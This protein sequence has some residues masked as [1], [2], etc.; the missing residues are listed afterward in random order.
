MSGLSR[1][2][3]L[4]IEFDGT[5]FVGWQIQKEQRSVQQ[6][7][8]DTLRQFLQDPE[9]RITGS[10]RTDAGVHALGMGVSFKTTHTIPLRGLVLG[11]NSQ[12]PL[13]IVA[14]DAREVPDDFCARHW[15]RG[16]RY[17]YKVW[18]S[19]LPSALQR[20]RAWHIH[21][22]LDLRA[23]YEGSRAL[24][25]RHDFS[26]FRAAGCSATHPFRDIYE[27]SISRQ[28]S[29]VFLEFEGSAFLRY[30]VRNLA[31][32]LLEVGKG[33]KP[34]EWIAELLASKDRSLGAPTAPAT[35]LY[36]VGVNYNLPP[37]SEQTTT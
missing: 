20:K 30:M 7:L 8:R 9:L 4:T 10:G 29:E 34:P 15:A 25:G 13:D 5:N 35:G 33:T 12:L 27:I 3:L 31:G 11:L 2:I 32:S 37:K 17:R 18:N 26:A 36:L 22:P 1:N 24:L 21:S 16:K 28:A 23:M 14:L 19:P 6:D